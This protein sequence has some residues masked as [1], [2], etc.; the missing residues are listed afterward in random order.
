MTAVSGRHEPTVPADVAARR[1]DD[2]RARPPLRGPRRQP[3]RHLAV[4]RG[5]LRRREIGRPEPVGPPRP[6][7]RIRDGQRPR[8]RRAAP[9]I[10]IDRRPLARLH[11]ARRGRL[12]A[13]A[14]R[15]RRR[16]GRAAHERPALRLGLACRAGRRRRRRH[17]DRLPALEPDRAVRPVAARRRADPGPTPTRGGSPSFNAEVLADIELREPVERHA[18][19]DGRDIQGWFLPGGDGPRPARPRDPRRPAHALRLVAGLGVPDPGGGRD[20]RVR[21][22]TRAARRA[23]ARRSTTPT[24]ATGVPGRCATCWPASTRSSPTAWPTPTGSA[25]PAARMAAT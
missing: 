18:T 6:D 17:P 14:D 12:R 25:S 22:A 23:T 1:S 4:R 13:V 7:A 8:A 20:R 9:L 15:G 10:P 24:T 3:Q 2:R 19:V 21:T 16:P 5:R 11:G